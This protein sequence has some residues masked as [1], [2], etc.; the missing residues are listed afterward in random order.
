MLQNI[1]KIHPVW[2]ATEVSSFGSLSLLYKGLKNEDK[3]IISK[4]YNLHYKAL[5]NWLHFLTYIR[6]IC[7]HHSRLWNKE[8]AIRPKLEGLS[9]EWLPPI[10]PRND[11]CFFALLILKHLLEHS[12]S[13]KAWV[14]NCESLINPILHKHAWSRHSMGIVKQWENHPLWLI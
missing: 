13:T 7:A 2:M 8:F 3:G 11:R 1:L 12:N 10:T 4:N 9:P 14:K 5:G 6:N